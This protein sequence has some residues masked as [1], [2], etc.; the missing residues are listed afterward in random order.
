MELVADSQKSYSEP[1]EVSLEAEEI[2]LATDRGQS[3][4]Q[5]V[6]AELELD[7]QELCA[8]FSQSEAT[9][10][11]EQF[12]T[13]RTELDMLLHDT[14]TVSSEGTY[15][16]Q[17]LY[18]FLVAQYDEAWRAYEY[19]ASNTTDPDAAAV[20]AKTDVRWCSDNPVSKKVPI[21]DHGD[22][23]ER[24]EINVTDDALARM[25]ARTAALEST[26]RMAQGSVEAS[27]AR[28]QSATNSTFLGTTKTTH[29][30]S[31]TARFLDVE[32]YRS[33]ILN[34]FGSFSCYEVRLHTL[35]KEIENTTVGQFD[36]WLKEE[37]PSAFSY[38]EDKSIAELTTLNV[39]ADTKN[40]LQSVGVKYETFVEWMNWLPYMLETVEVTER[41]LFGE[42]FAQYVITEDMAATQ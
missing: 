2:D 5:A 40:T 39:S 17:S 6:V 16:L 20:A 28:A 11:T 41:T 27:S 32:P 37:T 35:V 29:R 30:S 19:Y 8:M 21:T 36:R 9:K 1:D 3:A 4:F 31:L 10:R 42:L 13:V 38:I 18:D 14:Y 15:R 12:A 25:K 24:L 23:E 26:T 7:F 33:F 34:E 22:E